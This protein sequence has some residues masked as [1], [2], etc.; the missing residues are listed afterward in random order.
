MEREAETSFADELLDDLLPE[1]LDWRGMVTS[2]PVAALTVSAIG[3]YLLGRRHGKAILDALSRFAADEV[4]RN[5]SAFIG[6]D[7]PGTAD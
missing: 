1:S 3:G 5:V 2:Y 7:E 4:D 6:R